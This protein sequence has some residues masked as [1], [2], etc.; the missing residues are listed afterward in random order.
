MKRAYKSFTPNLGEN[1]YI[2][3][4][5]CVIGQVTLGDDVSVWPM[6]V[7][8]GDVCTITVGARSN[9]QDGS[10]LHVNGPSPDHP[11]GWPL[12]VGTDV[13]LGHQAILHAC[14]IGDRSLIGMGSTVLDGAVIEEEVLLA[15][16]SLVTPGKVLES[17]YL[18]AG[19]PAKQ[20][21]PLSADE[22]AFFVASA[23]H[24]AELKDDYLKASPP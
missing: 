19:R 4:Q 22:L 6:T 15:A 1:V 8:R 12:L 5:A 11:N 9:L 7:L 20:V 13:T 18:Y 17:G 23:A 24:Y 21:R 3:P 2:D 10:I 14:T 16:G